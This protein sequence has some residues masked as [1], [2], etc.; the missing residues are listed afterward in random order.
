MPIPLI[1]EDEAIAP[2]AVAVAIDMADVVMVI[3]CISILTARKAKEN[4]SKNQ[5]VA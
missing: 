3:P 5:D 2:E 1:D 4:E